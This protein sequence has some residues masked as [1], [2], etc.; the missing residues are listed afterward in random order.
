MKALIKTGYNITIFNICQVLKCR[1]NDLKKKTEICI[2]FSLTFKMLK[3]YKNLLPFFLLLLFKRVKIWII[4]SFNII[5]I[6][7]YRSK[8]SLVF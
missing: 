2:I 3:G 6:Y 1:V 4:V 5:F 7:D 8:Q